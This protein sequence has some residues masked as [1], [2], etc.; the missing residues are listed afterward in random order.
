MKI[1]GV[2]FDMDGVIFN[3]ED[4]WKRGF[5]EGN[6]KFGISLSEEFRQSI[7]GKSEALI[8]DEIRVLIPNFDADSYRDYMIELVSGYIEE[9]LFDVKA[10]FVELVDYLKARGIKVALATSSFRERAMSMF[11]KKG[12]DIDDIFDA[13]SF[14]ENV[15]AKSKPDPYIFNI[16]ADK[17][18][19]PHRECMV[20]EDSINGIHAAY[21]AEMI[22]VH[23]RDLIPPDD[24][25]S[26][27]S[28]ALTDSLLAVKKLL[29]DNID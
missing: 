19:V 8:R 29:E 27:H 16:T 9:G 17:M 23:V 22:P 11:R 15:G 5:I 21:N 25:V 1:S 3:S 26:E 12:M 24:F 14:L 18:R 28:F 7:C 4:L 2:I 10:G 13:A 20:L 6:R